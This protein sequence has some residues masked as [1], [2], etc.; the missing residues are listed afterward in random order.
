MATYRY[1]EYERSAAL[2]KGGALYVS[3]DTSQQEPGAALCSLD[4]CCSTDAKYRYISQFDS[5]A[6]L[7]FDFGWIAAGHPRLMNY[8]G[9]CHGIG[10]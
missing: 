4:T 10:V 1:T 2:S 6:T 8:Y 5:L 9:F 7:S 3:A